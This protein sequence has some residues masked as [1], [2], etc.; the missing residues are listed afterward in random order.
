MAHHG[1][2]HKAR[3]AD[4]MGTTVISRAVAEPV[5]TQ[6]TLNWRGFSVGGQPRPPQ[7]WPAKG[8]RLRFTGEIFFEAQEISGRPRTRQTQPLVVNGR[9][10]GP[11]QRRRAR[12]PAGMM[13]TARYPPES[14]RRE[15]R[16]FWS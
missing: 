3:S 7:G 15:P 6:E 1:T 11:A 5:S 8:G 12:N 9:R 16:L 10:E 2:L 13:A 14:L 4:F